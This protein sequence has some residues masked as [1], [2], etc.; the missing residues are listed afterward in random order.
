MNNIA[1]YIDHTLLK[2]EAT[3]DRVAKYCAEAMQ[4]GFASVCINPSYVTLA[5]V[6]LRGSRV[7]VCTVIGFP[8]GATSTDAKIY[9]AG[10]ALTDGATELDM[11]INIGRLHSGNTAYV[12]DEI[13]RL[14]NLTHSYEGA[15]L[16]VI[17]ET[18]LLTDDE[19]K[20]ACVLAE[21][22]GADAVKTCTGQAKGPGA[23]VKNVSLMRS[24]IGP[25]M[26]VKA[27]KD[28]STLA[29]MRVLIAAGAG[30]IGTSNAVPIM[31]ELAAESPAP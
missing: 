30:R 21:K 13:R 28:V 2:P 9:E 27:S 20:I 18:A 26:F 23:T 25:T 12:E 10:I 8:L 6:L 15:I 4:Y 3:P 16:K 29:I 17:I 19:I 7:A 11:V 31:M 22:A 24:I 14:A 5:A 1:S